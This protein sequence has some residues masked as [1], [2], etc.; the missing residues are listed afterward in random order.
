MNKDMTFF[1]KYA[2]NWDTT[3]KENPEKI[4]YLLQLA[5][6][7]TGA[8]V[9]DVGSGT[10]ILLPY[11]HKIIGPSGTITAVDFS[12][13]MLKKS[14]CK[15]GHLPNVNFFLGNILQI[16]LQKNFYNVAICLNVFP[17]FGNHKEDFIKQIYSILPSMGSLIIMHDISRA[18]V[19]GVH[20][21]C[22]E[23][24][25]HMLPPVNMTAHMLSQAG[26]K[27]AT[28]TENNTMY[29]IKGI[30]NQY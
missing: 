25:N 2:D 22:N 7:P 11:L 12:D 6:I 10:G 26:Y 17:H 28:A 23:I 30:K 16:S 24:K 18:T 29:F 14:Q 13:N 1:D 19:N 15:F 20:R 27:I 21:N 3:R 5:S 4:N 8:H 9:L